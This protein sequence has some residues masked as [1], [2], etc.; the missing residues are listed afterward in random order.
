M[1]Q[2]EYCMC[3]A[4]IIIIFCLLLIPFNAADIL[5]S[6]VGSPKNQ[7]AGDI[8]IPASVKEISEPAVPQ[9]EPLVLEPIKP[10]Q[11]DPNPL[12]IDPQNLPKIV[13]KN[14]PKEDNPVQVPINPADF[15]TIVDKNEPREPSPDEAEL[16]RQAQEQQTKAAAALDLK[17]PEQAPDKDAPRPPDVET[18][19]KIL[20]PFQIIDRNEPK[21]PLLE[22]EP[23]ME[24]PV[25]KPF[26]IID[27]NEPREPDP[28]P[29]GPG[30][31]IVEPKVS[32]TKATPESGDDGKATLTDPDGYEPD[33]TPDDPTYLDFTLTDQVQNH[34][35]HT[36]GTQNGNTYYGGDIDWFRFWAAAGSSYHIHS[37]HPTSC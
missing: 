17:S 11:E 7:P 23:V 36:L 28:N 4:I 1:F 27:K 30:S 25:A 26:V 15:F 6:L 24:T 32:N 35:L 31:Q 33:N 12:P 5:L 18:Q 9:P 2:W 8:V 29:H 22:P 19:P 20:P 3:K 21:E 13:D 10:F 34:T 14:E 16:A 37:D